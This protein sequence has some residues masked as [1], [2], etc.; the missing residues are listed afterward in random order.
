MSRSTIQ[1]GLLPPATSL[2]ARRKNPPSPPAPKSTAYGSA[3]VETSGGKQIAAAG[4]TLPQPVVVQVN[5][6]Q[7]TAVAGALV[8]FRGAFRGQFRSSR[9]N[10]RLERTVLDQRELGRAS[11]ALPD[12]GKHD[13]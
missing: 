13:H 10:N 12:H 6:D 3:I 5:D 9:R 7:G 11:R 2:C 4:T 8:E 1:T